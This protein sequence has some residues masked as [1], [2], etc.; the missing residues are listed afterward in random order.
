MLQREKMFASIIAAR[1][2]EKVPFIE[3]EV[4]FYANKMVIKFKDN[5]SARFRDTELSPLDIY[6]DD[7]DIIS[8]AVILIKRCLKM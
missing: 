6:D 8:D 1:L 7:N 3:V 5:N 4:N 2:R